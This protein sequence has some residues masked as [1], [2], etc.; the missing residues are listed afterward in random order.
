MTNPSPENTS[1]DVSQ[2]T[3]DDTLAVRIAAA[4]AMRRLN[5]AMVAHEADPDLLQRI[6]REATATAAVVEAGPRRERPIRRM[7]TQLWQA[8]VE[9]GQRLA[10]F[11]E[12]MVSGRANPMGIAMQP[13][14]EGDR[15][16]A[17]VNFGAAFEGAP[18]RAH[19][20]AVAAVMDDIMGYV[21]LLTATP[22]FTGRLG[23]SYRA[24][25]PVQTDLVASAWMDRRDGRKI[26]LVGDLRTADGDLIAEADALFVAI[27]RERLA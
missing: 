7:K 4:E 8:P 24:P 19:G 12:C 16:V 27:P 1:P 26:F 15:I 11:E 13:R 17:D 18:Q 5:H 10:H 20:G 9:E 3:A 22:A 23:I 25:T 6:A 21:L 2:P 14:R